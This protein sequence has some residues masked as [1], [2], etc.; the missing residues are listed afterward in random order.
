MKDETIEERMDRLKAKLAA[1]PVRVREEMNF[2]PERSGTTVSTPEDIAASARIAQ[3]LE[4]G[5][6]K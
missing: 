5:E 6:T 4:P 1:I 3:L 2:D